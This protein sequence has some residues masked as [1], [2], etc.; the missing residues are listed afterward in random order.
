MSAQKGEAEV[1]RLGLLL[2]LVSVDDVV[3]W[4]ADANPEEIG[5]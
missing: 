1:L 4:A 2:G 5:C 3:A